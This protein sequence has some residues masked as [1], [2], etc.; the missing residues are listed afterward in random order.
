MPFMPLCGCVCLCGLCVCLRV[1]LASFFSSVW[2]CMSLRE[3]C[4]SLFACT[5]VFLRVCLAPCYSSVDC[6]SPCAVYVSVNLYVCACL[7]VCLRVCV[8][9]SRIVISYRRKILQHAKMDR[10]IP[11][12]PPPIS[13]SQTSTV[14]VRLCRRV[15]GDQNVILHNRN[16]DAAEAIKFPVRCAEQCVKFTSRDKSLPSR[17]L[18]LGCAVGRSSFELTR[19]YDEVIGIGMSFERAVWTEDRKLPSGCLSHVREAA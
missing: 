4:M 17:A 18:D 7:C 10:K 3:L 9:R 13:H 8:G 12:P 2:L 15:L 1:S 11:P 5:C 6:M 16:I 14:R 19:F